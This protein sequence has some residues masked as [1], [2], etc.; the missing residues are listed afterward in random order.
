[1]LNYY[2]SPVPST[3]NRHVSRVLCRAHNTHSRILL[4]RTYHERTP[5]RTI[6][7][8]TETPPLASSQNLASGVVDDVDCAPGSKEKT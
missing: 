7:D 4:P 1:M 6:G 5:A 8:V 3:A 2:S